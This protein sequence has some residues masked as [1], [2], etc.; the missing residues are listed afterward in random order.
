MGLNCGAVLLPRMGIGIGA[1]VT[2]TG[3]AD[4]EAIFIWFTGG[5]SV[6]LVDDGMDVNFCSEFDNAFGIELLDNVLI[7]MMF[8]K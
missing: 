7:L 5:K 6:H 4:V 1:V 3:T 2:A 8:E